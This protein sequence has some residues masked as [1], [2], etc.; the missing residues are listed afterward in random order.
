MKE[1]SKVKIPT[2]LF[3]FS[4]MI[5]FPQ[6]WVVSRHEHGEHEVISTVVMD[7]PDTPDTPYSNNVSYMPTVLVDWSVCSSNVSYML[8]VLLRRDL[9][10]TCPACL[11]DRQVPEN[12]TGRQKFW[13]FCF[14]QAFLAPYSLNLCF[15]RV[16]SEK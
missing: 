3:S 11:L 5:W 13:N 12:W 8:R 1:L 14:G 16:I 2:R 6:H 7:A 9:A 10:R 15:C 4:S